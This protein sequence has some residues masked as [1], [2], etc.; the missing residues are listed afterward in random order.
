MTKIRTG[1]LAF[2]AWAGLAL[3]AFGQAVKG[4]D[5]KFKKHT[6]TR[7]FIAEGVAVADV[8]RDGKLDILAGSFWFEAPD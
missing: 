6:L 5:V 1:V 8:N 2:S 7:E 4:E 3:T